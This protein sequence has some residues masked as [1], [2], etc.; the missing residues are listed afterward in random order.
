[1]YVCYI[2]KYGI[3][4]VLIIAIKWN[5]KEVNQTILYSGIRISVNTSLNLMELLVGLIDETMQERDGAA[6]WMLLFFLCVV[7]VFTLGLVV[8][9]L[10]REGRREGE[11]VLFVAH[12][13]Y[14]VV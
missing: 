7:F 11:E 3:H 14:L 5:E 13:A 9:L 4:V 2:L 6:E 8:R 1:M 12:R 10:I